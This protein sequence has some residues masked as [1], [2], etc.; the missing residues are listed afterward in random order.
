M[1]ILT[2]IPPFWIVLYLI[3]MTFIAFASFGI[4]KAK[5]EAGS[6]RISEAALLQ[7]AFLGGTPGAYAGRAAF[8]HKTRKQ[9]FSNQLHGILILQLAAI[10]F[11]VTWFATG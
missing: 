8:R 11:I 4:D 10:A 3:A 5:A 7:W 6:R 9:P 1:E 2:D